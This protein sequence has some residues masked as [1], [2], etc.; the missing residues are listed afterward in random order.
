MDTSP[1]KISGWQISIWKNASHPMLLGKCKLKQWD[2][3]R[4]AKI[5][6]TDITKCLWEY[7]ATATLSH[8]WQKCKIVHSLWKT[9]W[10]FL[11]KLNISLPYDRAVTCLG[12]HPSGLKTHV[13]TK[14]HNVVVAALSIIVKAWSNR[15]ALR[16]MDKQTVVHPNNGILFSPKRKWAIKPWKDEKES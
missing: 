2:T 5:Q 10:W 12:F 7:E 3:I 13:H 4:M 16:W 15:D 8:C 9:I 11:T 1:K 14:L 6:N